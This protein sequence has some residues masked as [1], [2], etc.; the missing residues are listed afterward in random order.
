ML[1]ATETEEVEEA[2]AMAAKAAKAEEVE[3]KISKRQ[4]KGFNMEEEATS[5]AS[6]AS[7]VGK[8]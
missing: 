1:A 4:R 5:V 2:A 8:R 6:V 3:E 7:R